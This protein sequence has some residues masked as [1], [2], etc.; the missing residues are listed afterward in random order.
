MSYNHIMYFDEFTQ[1]LLLSCLT[2]LLLPFHS[3]QYPITIIFANHELLGVQ[4]STEHGQ[5]TRCHTLKRKKPN[6]SYLKNLA[7]NCS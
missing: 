4:L 1:F 5:P 6:S 2:P 3:S 7:I